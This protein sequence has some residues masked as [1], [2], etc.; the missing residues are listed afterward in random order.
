TEC[1]VS[2]VWVSLFRRR[3]ADCDEMDA[4]IRG[5][6]VP[7]AALRRVASEIEELV[8]GHRS[9]PGRSPTSGPCTSQ[10]RGTVAGTSPGAR[11]PRA[12][13]DFP[14]RLDSDRPEVGLHPVLVQCR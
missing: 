6:R 5:Y 9:C 3:V 13:A 4:G 11:T 7:L 12:L 14:R 8:A 1:P 10:G 2:E